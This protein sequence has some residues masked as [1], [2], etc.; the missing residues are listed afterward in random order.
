[1][2]NNQQALD[3][4]EAPSHLLTFSPSHLLTFSLLCFSLVLTAQNDCG[5]E[6]LTEEALAAYH[7]N[8]SEYEP[9]NTSGDYQDTQN[10]TISIPLQ[11]IIKQRFSG[12]LTDDMTQDEIEAAFL[13]CVR[14]VNEELSPR[15][16]FYVVKSDVITVNFTTFR[17]ERVWMVNPR[18]EDSNP[19]LISDNSVPIFIGETDFGTG[20]YPFGVALGAR[21]LRGRWLLH[22][23]GHYF[24]LFHTYQNSMG[25][26][27]CIGLLPDGSPVAEC[28]N[29]QFDGSDYCGD[30]ADPGLCY[31]D[32]ISST[33]PDILLASCGFNA[34]GFAYS[35]SCDVEVDGADYTYDIDFFNAMSNRNA[36][37][38][39]FLEEQKMRMY[40]VIT[41]P[42]LGVSGFGGDMS[43]LTD[44]D[45][46]VNTFV[47]PTLAYFR[48]SAPI[49]L[50][51]F[52][53]GE[54]TEIRDYFQGKI[55]LDY[56]GA[57]AV[58]EHDRPYIGDGVLKTDRFIPLG[59]EG[60]TVQYDFSTLSEECEPLE[61]YQPNLHIKASDVVDIINHILGTDEFENPYKKI[62]ADVVNDGSIDV[63]DAI[64]LTRHIEGLSGPLPVPYYQFMPKYPLTDDSG[65]VEAF[66]SD[67]FSATWTYNGEDYAYLPSET[68]KSYLGDVKPGQTQPNTLSFPLS[69]TDPRIQEADAV[70]FHAIRS[71]D[72]VMSAVTP[73]GVMCEMLA[74]GSILK[75]EMI[76]KAG[77]L[78]KVT[79]QLNNTKETSALKLKL[80]TKTESKGKIVKVFT[81]PVANS[82]DQ[83]QKSAKTTTPSETIYAGLTSAKENEINLLLV[84]SS[85]TEGGSYVEFYVNGLDKDMPITD[86]LELDCE[87]SDFY[88]SAGKEDKVPGK[89]AYSLPVQVQV[90]QE[91]AS[92]NRLSVIVSPNPV[93]ETLNLRLVEKNQ[94]QVKRVQIFDLNG[95]V[96]YSNT[97]GM[98]VGECTI[99]TVE[100]NAGF[101]FITVFLKGGGAITSKFVK[102]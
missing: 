14:Y 32:F 92:E 78:N 100:F 34:S 60:E 89:E 91:I 41:I 12:R 93:G 74:A 30:G 6:P 71:G 3:S 66:N 53:N 39:R 40:N 4:N 42:E 50:V 16:E 54:P 84:A 75:D 88:T 9:G 61:I 25:P 17:E 69:L 82:A 56:N 77:E 63:F 87:D 81:E 35:R 59:T 45:D 62:A 102:N 8:I 38:T 95:R 11:L 22:E 55:K 96:I 70:T 21:D 79:I 86:V 99:S 73:P 101:Y 23:L 15:I 19:G 5:V 37:A 51:R 31:G 58:E 90:G 65:F 43:F 24:G 98:S 36:G 48:Q 29:D 27:D 28:Y 72:V 97:I 13:S 18:I 76:L 2:Q 47:A 26:D 94:A 64:E 20:Q 7:Q 67:P 10:E 68:E 33:V 83:V 49:K 46:P 80:T 44:D 52:P 1:M 57:A 85:K